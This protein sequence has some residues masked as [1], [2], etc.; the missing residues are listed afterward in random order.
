RNQLERWLSNVFLRAGAVGYASMRAYTHTSEPLFPKLWTVPLSGGLP[1]VFEQAYGVA[2]RVANNP[3]PGVFCPAPAVFNATG[4][5]Y[6]RA[7]EQDLR[8]GLV[9]AV[10]IDH[11]PE[12]GRLK[13]QDVLGEPTMIVK[14]GGR[15]TNGHGKNEDKLHLYWRLT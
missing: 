7:R 3:E 2:Y 10:E 12:E 11:H 9:I 14:S 5:D 15:W 4:K 1:H 8:L 6:G 13:L